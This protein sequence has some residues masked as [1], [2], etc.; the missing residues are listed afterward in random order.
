MHRCLAFVER[1]DDHWREQNFCSIL[2]PARNSVH[3]PTA[4]KERA[5]AELT[6]I[7][8]THHT[9]NWWWGC[10]EVSEGCV[11]CYARTLAERWGHRVWGDPAVTPRRVLS[12]AIW[13]E[14]LKWHAQAEAEGVPHR[15][16][17]A[18]M[19]DIFEAHATAAEL[20][21]RIFELMERTPMLHWQ[22]LTKRPEHVLEMTPTH[23]RSAWPRNVWLLT[24]CEN[25]R[26][27]SLRL[28]WLIE[29]AEIA[30]PPVLGISAEPLLGPIDLTALDPIAP[31]RVAQM[32]RGTHDAVEAAALA[33]R[34]TALRAGLAA[35]F[36]DGE[37]ID[38][39]HYGLLD[40]VIVGG[41][42]GAHLARSRRRWMDLH[43][44]TNLKD[45]CVAAGTAFFF[46][47]ASGVRPEQ[48]PWLP[49]AAGRRWRWHQFPGALT[50][51]QPVVEPALP[52]L[53]RPARRSAA[54]AD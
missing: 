13:R 46:K 28:I 36:G 14:V 35:R 32:L 49:D 31:T 7:S 38:V 50:P 19:A 47:Q 17:T 52:E 33:A 40:W 4:G 26:Q 2:E 22:L 18:S 41:E 16:F 23:W 37:R 3:P 27:A 45:Q 10:R 42:S 48:G 43:W 34:W 53:T 39:L 11:H 30:R 51:P 9:A 24:S 6:K 8:W 15:V 29:V 20:R 12:D 1:P 5:M 44:A 54:V 21:P 25:H